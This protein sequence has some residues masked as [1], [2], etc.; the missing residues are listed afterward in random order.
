MFPLLVIS[1]SLSAEAM[2]DF[3]THINMLVKGG[4]MGSDSII[5]EVC[6]KKLDGPILDLGYHPLPDDLVPIQSEPTKDL[7]R[8]KI[9][10][11][12]YCLT[13]IQH[14]PVPKE[15]LFQSNYHYRASLTLDVV[16]GMRS[17]V[18]SMLPLLANFSDPVILDVGCNDGTLLNLFKEKTECVTIG[19]DPGDAIN[20]TRTRPDFAIQGYF[21]SHNSDLIASRFPKIDVVTF[22]NV[23]AHIEDLDSLCRNLKKL[24]SET[25]IVVIEN[26]YLG[27]VL[28]SVQFDTFYHEHPRTYSLRSF[29]FI[30]K[31][32]DVEILA[33]EFPSRYGGNIRV[34][35]S[36]NHLKSSLGFKKPPSLGGLAEETFLEKFTNLQDT[37]L[38]WRDATSEEIEKLITAHGPIIGKSLP[39][40]AV[41]LISALHLDVDKML[42][43]F[44]RPNSPK[45]GH[46]VPGTRIP[47]L[48]DTTLPTNS[49]HNLVVWSWHIINEITPYLRNLGFSGEIWIPMP[50]FVKQS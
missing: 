47:I 41:M 36:K 31:K 45:V 39:A 25:T 29:E 38:R 50:I 35:M 40:R 9:Q 6:N 34:L 28:E 46:F 11:C 33:E 48:S 49:E 10:L 8:Q 26:H 24:I 27:S 3:N 42:G 22:T 18:D 14:F 7:F 19:I 43:V 23:F 1:V 12:N 4:E 2:I 16:N 17:L 13:A 32:L 44:E 37:F 5:C 30:A 21:D 15:R 20:N